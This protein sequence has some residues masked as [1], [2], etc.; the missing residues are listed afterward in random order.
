MLFASSGEMC[1]AIKSGVNFFTDY[2]VLWLY[3]QYEIE[4][5]SGIEPND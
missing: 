3:R 4:V 2:I 5:A 1:V